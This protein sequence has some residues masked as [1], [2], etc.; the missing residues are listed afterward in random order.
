MQ[1]LREAGVRKRR[2]GAT[3]GAADVVHE[4]VPAVAAEVVRDADAE[5]VIAVG[6]DITAEAE[7]RVV[8]QPERDPAAQRRLV[9]GR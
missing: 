8:V 4:H 9:H 7:V 1:Q 5:G 2:V 6:I 3:A